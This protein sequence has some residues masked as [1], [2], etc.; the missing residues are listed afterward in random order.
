MCLVNKFILVIDIYVARVFC[1]KQKTAYEMRMSDW[2]SD[3]CSSDLRAQ[4]AR[5]LRT[6][7]AGRAGPTG[8]LRRRSMDMSMLETI[9]TDAIAPRLSDGTAVSELIDFERREVSLRVHHDQEI[10]EMEMER[11]EEH[12]TELKSLMLI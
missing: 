5:D 2:S 1:F 8:A 4:G 6:H 9:E 12:T 7:E 10:F 11:S 3:V